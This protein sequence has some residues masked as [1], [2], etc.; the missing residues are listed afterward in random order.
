M[1]GD[2]LSIDAIQNMQ[3]KSCTMYTKEQK[4]KII[5]KR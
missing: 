2:L 3:V 4:A 1:K 5:Q